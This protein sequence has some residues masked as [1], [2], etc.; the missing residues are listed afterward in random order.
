MDRYLT[1]L[2]FLLCCFSVQSRPEA[3]S[4]TPTKMIWISPDVE[5]HT[6]KNIHA[7]DVSGATL[8]LL[9]Q[10]LPQLEVQH[11]Q[12]NNERA[13]SILDSR[14]NA[15]TGRKLLTE[16]RRRLYQATR[17][18]QVVYP[19]HKLYVRAD[20]ALWQQ[21]RDKQNQLTLED[22]LNAAGEKEFGI[23]GG[24]SYGG[25]IDQ[26]LADPK[27]QEKL[28]VRTAADM[29]VGLVD[30]L[31]EGR[32]AAVLEYPNAFHSF[33]E[34]LG[35]HSLIIP[36]HLQELPKQ[37]EGHILCSKTPAGKALV[38]IFDREI[39]KLSQQQSYLDAHLN[40]FHPASHQAVIDIYDEVYGTSFS[41]A[42]LTSALS[43]SP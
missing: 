4:T 35:G 5:G 12:A 42:P 2:I 43:T 33:A 28:W 3:E 31:L 36:L 11:I 26:A 41:K 24:R 9:Q 37:V 18:P 19:G 7:P 21:I 13:M 14:T 29:S 30:M 38:E 22:V 6:H 8:V 20:R 27:W 25:Q 23:V 10:A 17:L 1:A 16:E 15:C 40:W 34:K 39:A 32:L